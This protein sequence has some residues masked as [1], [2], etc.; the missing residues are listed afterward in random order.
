M[1]GGDIGDSP[2]NPAHSALRNKEQ[3]SKVEMLS[4]IES[5]NERNFPFQDVEVVTDKDDS[6]CLHVTVHSPARSSMT[7][8]S[9][10][11]SSTPS[12]FGGGGGGE[13]GRSGT[14]PFLSAVFTFDD[15]IRCMAA[16]QR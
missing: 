15:H 16:K 10:S 3:S 11:S 13:V 1:G 14:Q 2:R 8:A 6:R 7:P 9:S 4:S 12:R 5:S